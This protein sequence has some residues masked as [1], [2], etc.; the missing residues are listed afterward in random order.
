MTHRRPIRLGLALLLAAPPA[1]LVEKFV[2][3]VGDFGGIG[4]PYVVDKDLFAGLAR[5]DPADEV[6][7]P[8]QVRGVLRDNQVVLVGDDRGRR[9][10]EVPDD[11]L[12][13]FDVGLLDEVAQPVSRQHQLRQHEDVGFGVVLRPGHGTDDPLDVALQVTDAIR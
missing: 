11:A 2:E 13:F 12:A 1:L 10:G 9:T 4:V 8:L 6:S 3:L 5:V 7:D